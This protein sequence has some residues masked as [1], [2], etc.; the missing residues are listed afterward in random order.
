MIK[1]AL[2]LFSLISVSGLFA[3]QDYFQ[4][5][6]AYEIH[7]TL[8]DSAHTLSAQEKILYVN[9]SPDTLNYLMFHLWPNAYKND[10][11]AFAKQQLRQRNTR[12]HYAKPKDRGYIDS[13]DFTV[14]G[15]K[16]K[17]KYH[18]SYIDVAKLYLP[19]PL[20]PGD[21]ITI[22]TPFFVKLP[23][24]FSRLGHTGKHYEITQWYPK[25]AVYDRDGWHAMPYLNQGEFYSEFGQFDVYITLPKNYRIMATGDLVDGEAEYAWLDSLAQEGD[26]L[27]ALPKKEF[28]ARLK[29]LRKQ[30]KK[31]KKKKG[32]APK[33]TQSP[34]VLKT[35]HFHQEKVHDFAWFADQHWI[36]RKG[37]LFLADSTRKVTLWSFYLPKNAKL[38]ENSIE[39][40][41]DA[42]Y[43]YSRFYGDYP[44]NHIT[45]VDGDLSAGGGMEYPNITV[46]SSGGSKN[47]LE[48][49][50]MH[51][52][53][54]NWFYGILGSNERDHTW[55]DEGLNEYSNIRY[56]EK[57]YASK[58]GQFVL[59]D[60]L[61]NK[62]G[63]GKNASFDWL[64]YIQYLPSARSRDAQ[65]LNLT[66]NDYERSNYGQHY[67][68]T[69]VFSWFLEHYLGEQKIDEIFQDY[70]ETWKFK[71]PQPEDFKAIFRKHVDEDLSW[72]LEDVFTK[73]N[74]IDYGI[75]VHGNQ[76]TVTNYGTMEAPVEIAFYDQNDNE[77]GRKWL[78]GFSGSTAV[79]GPEGSV[80]AVIDPDEFMP[81][82]DRTNHT[83]KRKV[84]VNFVW[85]RPNYYDIDINLMP[86]LFSYNVYNGF[87][88]GLM[89]YSG[90]TPGFFGKG[91]A[92]RPM[93]D[94]SH[95]RL[96]GGITLRRGLVP[97]QW[98]SRGTVSA[99][100]GDYS[101]R[102]GLNISFE[103]TMK[104]P[105]I[106]YPR[107]QI[108]AQLFYH[109]IDASA[110]DSSLY[111]G[112]QFTVGNFSLEREWSPNPFYN[113]S[114][115][116]EMKG[117]GDFLRAAF[118]AH[119]SY[120]YSK[121][122]NLG[123][124][125]WAGTFLNGKKVPLQYR[126]YFSGGVDPDFSKNILD[127][128]GGDSGLNI[129]KDQ[130]LLDGPGLHGLALDSSQNPLSTTGFAWGLNL[131][132]KTGKLLTLFVDAAGGDGLAKT[133]VDAG[134]QIGFLIL[135]LYQSWE[136]NHKYP[137]NKNWLLDRLRFELNLS[138]MV[139]IGS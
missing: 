42:G 50:I 112:G 57:K 106:P 64:N 19:E 14:N 130:Y 23:Q 17:W 109:D 119:S 134:V 79:E 67:S 12:F 71:H 36:V 107:N 102:S 126:T 97:N 86:W 135:P 137:N 13:L 1:K 94:F 77:L 62:A 132:H 47:L 55:M 81:D 80:K 105:I 31:R 89:M 74:Y 16:I 43:W 127:R 78:R 11:T 91:L 37:T 40:I 120:R 73:T 136:P 29:E 139:R 98:L 63:I 84:H 83:T 52:V 110:V 60:F 124:R 113:A 118:A 122:G 116:G 48:M 32:K 30:D 54:H 85:D 92:V 21:S 59:Q 70:Y 53:G 24:V 68:K 108:K 45:A 38:W 123:I 138:R 69:A 95:N 56:W 6:V 75:S 4:Q 41:H 121:K 26:S 100:L 125:L 115:T 104:A 18:P 87:T 44:Y 20:N 117:S 66:A 88:P 76:F 131:S 58:G 5:Y 103:G 128:T 7:V 129:Y 133:Y 3:Q 28:K 111:E 65:P 96:V 99:A 15:K 93:W 39:Y 72:Y 35:L 25:P 22:E 2:L 9:H 27:H 51:E 10:S 61:Q 114:I 90:F 101:G 49:V 34:P 46:I 33:S 82:A 8:N